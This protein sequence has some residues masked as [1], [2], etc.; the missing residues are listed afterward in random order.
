MLQN[1]PDGQR[2]K[3]WGHC[4]LLCC[5]FFFQQLYWDIIHIQQNSPIQS[6]QF[7]TFYFILFFGRTCGMKKFPGQGSNPCH[8]SDNTES[9]TGCATEELLL[10]VFKNSRS[11]ATIT[12][13]ILECFWHSR[14]KSCAIS[15]SFQKSQSPLAWS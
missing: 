4:L 12:P 1:L 9:L 2:N 8:S 5:F 15:L 13:L 11:Y 7:N 14:K 6:M 10:N 3:C